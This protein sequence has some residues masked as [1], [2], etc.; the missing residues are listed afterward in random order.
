MAWRCWDQAVKRAWRVPL[1]THRYTVAHLL[2]AGFLSL[3]QNLL[4][5]Y[6]GFFQNLL[7]SASKEVQIVANIVSRNVLTCTGRN[8][9]LISEE[10][11]VNPWLAS[12]SEVRSRVQLPE[13]PVEQE[14]LLPQLAAALEERLEREGEEGEDMGFLSYI[15]DSF[16]SY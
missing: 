5:L 7:K 1:S 12:A 14:W 15:I 9:Q 2:G 11:N 16:A 10:F 4:P 8:L 6:L 13:I 3:R